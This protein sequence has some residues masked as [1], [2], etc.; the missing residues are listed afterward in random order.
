MTG[1]QTVRVAAIQA[2]PVVLD[3]AATVEK[4][5]GLL[6]GAAAEG[7]RLAVLPEAFVSLYPS[8]AWAQGAPAF[9]GWDELWERLW[10]SSVDVGGPHVA[11]LVGACRELDLHCVIGVNER[12]DDRPGTLYNTMLVLGPGGVLHRHRKLMPT[13]QER[14]FHGVGAGDDLGV[15]ELPGVGRVG[16]LICWE[17]RMPLARYAVYRQG[18][19]IWAAPT[20]DD[21]D[22]WLASM[23]HI[24]I[25]S[26]AY[27]VSVPQYIPAGAFGP[28]FPVP[29][30]D[31]KAVLGDGG[32]AIVEPAWGE[33][34]AGP[35][36]GREGMLLA[37][38]DLRR[39]LRAKR[40]FDVVGHYAREDVLRPAL[41]L[42]PPAGGDRTS[43]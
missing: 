5:V 28:D 10:E 24:A 16:G 25:E 42:D 9:S 27:V 2:T 11:R 4:A 30:P 20:A 14:V 17:N 12:E 23:R 37:D 26:G 6:A 34:V 3:A 13:M 36:R 21:S 8:N 35:L 7:A 18:P 1:L 33:V 43:A 29:L 32:A 22:G 41:G 15:A 31:G 38:C 40:W 39:T 19:Q